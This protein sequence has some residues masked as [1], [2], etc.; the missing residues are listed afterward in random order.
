MR[1][2]P[3]WI[4]PLFVVPLL[5]GASIYLS[6]PHVEERYRT[7]SDQ[8]APQ[9]PKEGDLAQGREGLYKHLLFSD[10]GDRRHINVRADTSDLILLDKGKRWDVK[11]VFGNVEAEIEE[12]ADVVDRLVCPE[13]T[14]LWSDRTL[15]ITHPSLERLE[16]EK[17]VLKGTAK[18]AKVHFTSFKEPSIEVE[19]IEANLYL[20]D[21]VL[22]TADEGSSQNRQIKGLVHIRSKNGFS[23]DCGE[24]NY[25]SDHKIQLLATEQVPVVHIIALHKDDR[26]D[27]TA[28]EVI[29]S[30]DEPLVAKGEVFL[31]L[32][33]RGTLESD[34][35]VLTL[36]EQK[37]P[38]LLEAAGSC[39][40]AVKD[41]GSIR[42]NALTLDFE[43]ETAHFV[44][45]A[46]QSALFAFEGKELWLT[47]QK[48]TSIDLLGPLRLSFEGV[49]LISDGHI[50]LT[51]EGQIKSCALEGDSEV[52]W[53]PDD[54]EPLSLAFDGIGRYEGDLVEVVAK[55]GKQLKFSHQLGE[56]RG[57]KGT[58]SLAGQWPLTLERILV[59]GG[60]YLNH[61]LP[62]PP[63]LG[64]APLQYAFA[65]RLIFD[66]KNR[67]I[68][69][70]ADGLV[71]VF[72]NTNGVEMSAKEVQVGYGEEGERIQGVGDVRFKFNNQS[73][74]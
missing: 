40:L 3:F 74:E 33:G 22:I 44:Y 58:F 41:R 8:L 36:N 48:T 38:T 53:Y 46:G 15:S 19:G 16:K 72:D 43:K 52:V 68:V 70:S 39:L 69:L 71:R 55:E 37:E 47:G 57:D 61:A 60:V 20:N 59:E 6:W 51:Y 65:D 25:L 24:V 18:G 10:G 45:P 64:L 9:L 12:G 5:Y 35:L 42:S 67:E 11:E 29:L 7:M 4:A 17:T 23:A 66:P 14:L 63:Q 62:A 31:K 50:A 26:A 54:R 1:P 2:L 73:G 56:V 34:M 13:G 28:H 32:E 27:L 21:E 30:N 49:S